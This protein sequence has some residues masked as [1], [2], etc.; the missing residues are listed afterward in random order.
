MLKELLSSL[1]EMEKHAT[2][3][4]F[5]LCHLICV[6]YQTG[7][8]GMYLG[9]YNVGYSEQLK[10]FICDEQ[11]YVHIMAAVNLLASWLYL[12]FSHRWIYD[13]FVFLLYV[14]AKF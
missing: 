10:K 5:C 13:Q 14:I 11:L 2:A 1:P 12:S 9:F 8:I 6:W 3:N 7:R 4:G